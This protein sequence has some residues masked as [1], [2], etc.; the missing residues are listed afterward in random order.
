MKIGIAGLG[1]IGGSLARAIK[2]F[3]DHTVYVSNRTEAVARRAVEEGSADA[4]LTDEALS[5]LDMLFVCLYPQAT[6]DY[7]REKA[8]YIRRGSLVLDCSGVKSV[9][10]EAL[11]PL[12]KRFGFEFIG[13]HPMAGRERSG[14]DASDAGLFAGA[15][16]ILVPDGGSDGGGVETVKRLCREIGFGRVVITG[17]QEHDRRIAYTSQLAHIVSGAYIKSD[18]AL[19]QSGF[20]AGSFRDMTRV[21]YLNE[22]MWTELFMDNRAPL[23]EEIK[24]LEGHLREYRL[25]LENGDADVLRSLLREGRERKEAVENYDCQSIKGV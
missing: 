20:S 12:A 5:G 19:L 1:L 22:D 24:T 17:A 23:A 6:I 25:A 14:Y 16:M 21:A 2:R 3:T 13:G 4:A 7:I 9:V 18:T 11:F 8:P 10:C 15:S